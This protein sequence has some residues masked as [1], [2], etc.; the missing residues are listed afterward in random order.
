M[1]E[2]KWS[3]ELLFIYTLLDLCMEY[4]IFCLYMIMIGLKLNLQYENDSD[5]QLFSHA[6]D[7]DRTMYN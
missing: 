7:D 5:V 4:V 6:K 3:E 2:V 1:S